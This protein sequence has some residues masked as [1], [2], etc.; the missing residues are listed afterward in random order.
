MKLKGV[1]FGRTDGCERTHR[2]HVIDLDHGIQN[3]IA[4][5]QPTESKKKGERLSCLE[6]RAF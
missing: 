1:Y 4:L 6:A 5:A 2:A 3:W